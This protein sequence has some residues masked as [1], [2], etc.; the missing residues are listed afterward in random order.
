MSF[1]IRSARIFG[2]PKISQLAGFG[3]LNLFAKSLSHFQQKNMNKLHSVYNNNVVKQKTASEGFFLLLFIFLHLVKQ[4]RWIKFE[5]CLHA[6][7]DPALA[8]GPQ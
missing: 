2:K 1:D 7:H 8:E 5:S 3:H 6:E 4:L